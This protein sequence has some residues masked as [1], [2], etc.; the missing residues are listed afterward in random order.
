VSIGLFYSTRGADRALLCGT[1][2]LRGLFFAAQHGSS[3]LASIGALMG[4]QVSGLGVRVSGFG[5][6][7]S[8][9]RYRFRVSRLGS[10]GSGFGVR[11]SDKD[12][13]ARS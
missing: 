13:R 12:L 5:F 7:V 2:A 11:G 1:R 8:G 3:R 10:R 4:F 6:R 9:L